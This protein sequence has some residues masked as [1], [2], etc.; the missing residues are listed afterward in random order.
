MIDLWIASVFKIRMSHF[1]PF[2]QRTQPFSFGLGKR[3][4]QYSFGL[5]KRS[6]Y[7]DGNDISRYNFGYIPNDQYDAYA[8]K[9]AID[10]YLEAKRTGGF[11]FGLGKLFIEHIHR[12]Y[13]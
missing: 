8:Q 11:N 4:R 9:D 7:E 12:A 1:C 3:T 13:A 2:P 10:N 6:N 5:G